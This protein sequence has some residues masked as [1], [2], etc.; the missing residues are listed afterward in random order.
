MF[1]IFKNPL[2]VM[3][4]GYFNPSKSRL[5]TFKTHTE[6]T[7]QLKQYEQEL[8]SLNK[9]LDQIGTVINDTVSDM[10]K[11]ETEKCKLKVTFGRLYQFKRLCPFER[12]YHV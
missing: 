6:L 12:L 2:G 4:G 3:S 9:E 7:K 5:H 8:L 1:I 11:N 10:Q